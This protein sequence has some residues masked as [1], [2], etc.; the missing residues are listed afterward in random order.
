LNFC[1]PGT[2]ESVQPD[3]PIAFVTRAR[4]LPGLEVRINFGMHAGRQATPAEIDELGRMI[5]AAAP[6]VSVVSEI[7]HELSHE[8]EVSVHQVRVELSTENLPSDYG[9]LDDL[10][11]RLISSVERWA[12]DCIA[13]RHTEVAEP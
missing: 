8:S 10:E 4:E 9:R 11:R 5:L 7:R 1:A 6:A 3:P 2:R 12:R 13:E